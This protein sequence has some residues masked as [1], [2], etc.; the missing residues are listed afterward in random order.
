[1]DFDGN[2][3]ADGWAAKPASY[4]SQPSLPL[5]DVEKGFKNQ[6]IPSG[7]RVKSIR[8]CMPCFHTSPH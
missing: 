7:K 5:F 3:R 6:N 2:E 1:M 8:N 4:P